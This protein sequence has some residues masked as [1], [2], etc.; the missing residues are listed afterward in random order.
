LF[1]AIFNIKT[2]L[3]VLLVL[4]VKQGMEWRK[5]KVEDLKMR[6]ELSKKRVAHDLGIQAMATSMVLKNLEALPVPGATAAPSPT[7]RSVPSPSG[8]PEPSPSPFIGS[9]AEASPTPSP[10]YTVVGVPQPKPSLTSN[11]DPRLAQLRKDLEAARDLKM[12]PEEAAR[13]LER[14][15]NELSKIAS[16]LPQAS[17]KSNLVKALDLMK[18]TQIS[19]GEGITKN[20]R[21]NQ[22]L[23]T[24][25]KH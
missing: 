18:K 25:P 12:D 17:M 21:L 2:L 19:A 8:V 15:Q 16:A 7:P 1:H 4:F 9:V 20:K 13:E 3:A 11:A 24:S 5:R 14:I 10:S 23:G 22:Q 6:V